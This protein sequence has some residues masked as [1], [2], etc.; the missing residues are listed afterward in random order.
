V[1]NR[2]RDLAPFVQQLLPAS[3][4]TS[5]LDDLFFLLDIVLEIL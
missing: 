2:G 5:H 4:R 3:S 1:P